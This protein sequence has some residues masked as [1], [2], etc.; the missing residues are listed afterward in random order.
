MLFDQNLPRDLNDPLDRF[1]TE[2]EQKYPAASPLDEDEAEPR[3]NDDDDD[4]ED[5]LDDAH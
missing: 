5:R 4:D 2:W 3:A 1:W